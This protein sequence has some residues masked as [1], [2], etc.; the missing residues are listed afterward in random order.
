MNAEHVIIFALGPRCLKLVVELF[1]NQFDLHVSLTNV[2]VYPLTCS[3][4]E[5]LPVFEPGAPLA[6]G[7]RRHIIQ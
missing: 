7:S 2:Q 5:I 4:P 3:S 1:R 6:N